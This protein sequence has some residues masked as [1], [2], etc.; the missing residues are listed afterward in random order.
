VGEFQFKNLVENE[1]W[2]MEAKAKKIL[3]NQACGR[4]GDNTTKQK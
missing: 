4:A 3:E 2:L 1:T